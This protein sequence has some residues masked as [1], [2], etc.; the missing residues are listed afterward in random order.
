MDALTAEDIEAAY[1]RA[2]SAMESVELA[3]ENLG[4]AAEARD[5]DRDAP[6][7]S[8]HS[9]KVNASAS[10]KVEPS[11]V[12]DT[13]PSTGVLHPREVI[14]AA[15]FVGGKSLTTRRLSQM[16]GERETPEQIDHEIAELNSIYSAEGRPY[17]IDFGEGGYRLVLRPEFE[18][19]RDAVF[20][21]GPKDVKLSQDALE[22]LAF[23]AYRQPTTLEEL[24]EA[25]KEKA[26]GLLRQL[27]RR[28]LIALQRDEQGVVFY[29][30]TPRFLDVFGLRSLDEL[31]FPE[32]LE[33]K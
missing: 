23:V 11:A 24:Q 4:A 6:T 13:A 9:E 21:A 7:S 8:D 18:P 17:Q 26:G 29:S 1:E 27:L 12:I 25:G 33:L 15:L 20:G 5:P 22:V 32:D 31:P 16:F 28:Q 30:T 10:E 19:V 14:E 2:L 3:V